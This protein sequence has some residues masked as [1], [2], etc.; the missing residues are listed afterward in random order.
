MNYLKKELYQYVRSD[1]QIFEFIQKATQDGLWYWDL[2]KPENEWM[3]PVFWTTLGYDPAEKPHKVSVWKE[4]V[5]N[6]D[7]KAAE[8]SIQQ[9][10]ANPDSLFDEIIRYRH[11]EGHTVWIRCKGMAI[12]DEEGKPVR[13]LG[14]HTD[15]SDQVR[16]EKFLERCN[17]AADIGYW[18]VNVENELLHWSDTVKEIH[19][20]PVDYE[21]EMNTAIKFYPEGENRDKIKAAVK[22]AQNSGTPYDL[23]L[24]LQTAKKRTIWVRS[25]GYAEFFNGKCVRLYGTLQ[26]IDEQK[27]AEMALKDSK[28]QFSGL[29]ENI[30]GATYQFTVFEDDKIFKLE[31][32]SGYVKDVTGY[33]ADEFMNGDDLVINNIIHED[34]LDKATKIVRMAIDKREGWQVDYRIY[35]KNGSVRWVNERGNVLPG[36][37]SNTCKIIGVMFD[38]TDHVR[39]Q[40]Q[41]AKEKRNMRTIIDNIPVNVYMKDK[42]RRKILANKSEVKYS[43][44]EKEED[45]LGKTDEELYPDEIAKSY[46]SEDQKVL[47]DGISLR[48]MENDMGFGRWAIVSKIP[49]TDSEGNVESIVGVSVD[50]TERKKAELRIKKSEDQFRKTFENSANGMAIISLEG[51]YIKTNKAYCKIIGYTKEELQT[52]TYKDITHPDDLEMNVSLVQHLIKGEQDHYMMDKRY[53]HKSGKIVWA[54]LA[55]SLIHDEV[56]DKSFIISQITDITREKEAEQQLNE[57]LNKLKSILAASTRVG[58]ISTDTEGLITSFNR[59]AENL[60]GYSAD[61]IIGNESPLTLH[62]KTEMENRGNEQKNNS[63]EMVNDFEV[64][65]RF[66]RQTKFETNEWE[67]IRKDGSTLPAQLTITEIRSED[68]ELRGY[69]GIVSDI[70]ELKQRENELEHLLEIN[71]EQNERLLNFAHIVSHNLKGH[72]SN[73]SMIINLLE[74]E[75]DPQE[76]LQ[77]VKML[78]SASNNLDETVKN[79]TQIVEASTRPKEALRPV[80]I[81]DKLEKAM[82]SLSAIIKEANADVKIDADGNEEV[83]AIPAYVES[84]FHNLLSNAIKYRSLKRTPKIRIQVTA[85]KNY[86]IISFKDNGRGIDLEGDGENLFGMYKTFHGNEDARG[87]GLFITK[88]QIDTMGGK[89]E[90]ESGPDKGSI[91]RV[92]LPK[93]KNENR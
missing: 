18:E 16:K 82:G 71:K 49:V 87:I 21:P 89:I 47:K 61:E 28:D 6:D 13:M 41:L 45:V 19:D 59:G 50:I 25:L 52:R 67:L 8:K 57:A 60:L 17:S 39:V 86:R 40:K 84:I 33:T 29:V 30:P 37:S 12:R 55:A 56:E 78:R 58:I 63:R 62:L 32:I 88:N 92:Y 4:V 54:H 93:Q 3:N 7:L 42:H 65:T 46:T 22:E 36:S 73:F 85:N 38:Q 44:F 80:N 77:S 10:L 31:Y 76:I 81:K 68:G 69:L 74:V 51:N 20:L 64:L 27:R 23:V 9:H 2:E 1:N 91:F 72:A 34:D 43:G 14:A 90:V 79:L 83:I 70:T 53:I 15:I 11:K 35:H 26:D 5:H 75:K 48:E 24:Q 66:V